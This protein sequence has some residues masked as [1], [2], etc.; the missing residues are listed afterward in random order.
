MIKAAVSM[1]QDSK[2]FR[3]EPFDICG[4]WNI[5]PGT[6]W[7]GPLCRDDIL[8]ECN[9]I[10]QYIHLRCKTAICRPCVASASQKGCVSLSLGWVDLKRN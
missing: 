2:V 3:G 5:I 1:S 9:Y 4:E 7:T 8:F 6:I 10:L